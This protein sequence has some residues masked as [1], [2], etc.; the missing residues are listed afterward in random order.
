MCG[1]EACGLWTAR[2]TIT[3]QKTMSRT[4]GAASHGNSGMSSNE[5]RRIN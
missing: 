1:G 5:Q 3:T 4:C 2:F